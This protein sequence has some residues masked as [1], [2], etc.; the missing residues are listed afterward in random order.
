[1]PDPILTTHRAPGE[2][3]AF[4]TSKSGLQALRSIGLMQG[5]EHHLGAGLHIGRYHHPYHYHVLVLRGAISYRVLEGGRESR[6]QV[7]PG[8]LWQ[9]PQPVPYEFWSDDDGLAL[10]WSLLPDAPL[11]PP[12]RV[13]VVDDP[14]AVQRLPPLF[15]WILGDLAAPDAEAS[16]SLRAVAGLLAATLRRMAGAAAVSAPLQPL[17]RTVYAQPD[18]PWT[19]DGL[20]ARCGMGRYRLIRLMRRTHACTP[21]AMVAR[22]RLQRA[23]EL[24][25]DGDA[26]LEEIAG[27]V[28]YAS[29]FA[30]SKAFRAHRG[31]SP[32]DFRRQRGG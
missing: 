16:G 21:M 13:C 27:R 3:P 14:L 30:L 32:R 2:Q 24:L 7:T 29:G 10:W 8:R 18:L 22:L 17:W 5:G 15:A 25:L 1:M 26:T 12:G 23:E 19:L 31:L 6:G 20:A 9:C 4:R 28:G 11:R